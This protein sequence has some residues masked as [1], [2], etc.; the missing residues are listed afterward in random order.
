MELKNI[1]IVIAD[2]SGYSGFITQNQTALLHAEE[3]I[4]Q[5]IETV[6]STADYPLTIN[7]LE[8]DAA[9]M[10]AEICD[11]ESAVVPDVLR[12]VT[13]FFTQFEQKIRELTGERAQCPCEACQRVRELK[14]KVI[15]HKGE[16]AIKKIRHFEE[17]AGVSVILAHRLLKNSL[18]VNQYI[19]LTE[20]V[21][22]YFD[23]AIGWK[24][25]RHR[26]SY[27]GSGELVV[28]VVKPAL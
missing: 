16:A 10:Y 12:Q 25:F 19:L 17:L 26:E 1:I 11:N 20:P 21:A 4:S 24:S 2:V 3:I 22:A 8:G 28:T 5:L 14:L 13:E 7:K 6:I 23:N 15:V 9:L 27:P 18:P